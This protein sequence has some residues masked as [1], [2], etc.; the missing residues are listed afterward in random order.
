LAVS[1]TCAFLFQVAVDLLLGAAVW[2]CC[3]P[4]V[5]EAQDLFNV[6]RLSP[7]LRHKHD[8]FSLFWRYLRRQR[9]FQLAALWHHNLQLN[10][11]HSLISSLKSFRLLPL[12]V[13][14]LSLGQNS[15]RASFSAR[16]RIPAPGS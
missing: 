3:P 5:H 11:V 6:G 14:S 12:I 15:S 7:L 9:D 13:A 8:D 2:M 4:L 1:P 10:N 16:R